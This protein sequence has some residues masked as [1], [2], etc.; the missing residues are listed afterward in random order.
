MQLYEAVPDDSKEH[1]L[2][3]MANIFV[4]P[5]EVDEWGEKIQAHSWE[6]QAKCLE[7][8]YC[9]FKWPMQHSLWA[10]AYTMHV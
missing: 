2:E 4:T 8:I 1:V 9:A 10:L 7:W 3:H 6:R 5:M